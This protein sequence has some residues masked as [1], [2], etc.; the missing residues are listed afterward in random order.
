MN[1]ILEPKEIKSGQ[2]EWAQVEQLINK[3]FP[4]FVGV[5]DKYSQENFICEAVWTTYDYPITQSVSHNLR[6]IKNP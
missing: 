1:S 6:V 3:H 4:E 5:F 2:V